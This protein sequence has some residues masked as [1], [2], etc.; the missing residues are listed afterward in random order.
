[1][2]KALF[3]L[4]CTALLLSTACQAAGFGEKKCA[5]AGVLATVKNYSYEE[6]STGDPNLILLDNLYTID[7]DVRQ[8][9]FGQLRNGPLRIKLFMHAPLLKKTPTLYNLCRHHDGSWW[10]ADCREC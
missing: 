5:S 6:I 3:C 9:R 8:V 7:I 10:I 4:A 1:M 2:K